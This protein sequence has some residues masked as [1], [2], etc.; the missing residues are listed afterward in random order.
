M[1][2]ILVKIWSCLLLAALIGWLIGW[3]LGK[4]F[5]RD[6]AEQSDAELAGK[7]H[8]CLAERRRLEEANRELEADLMSM[9]NAVVVPFDTDRND[10]LAELE[11]TRQLLRK[12]Q[13]QSEGEK[14]LLNYPNDERERLSRELPTI[15]FP[16]DASEITTESQLTLDKV[17]PMLKSLNNVVVEIE[18][19]TDSIDN[20]EHNS[21]LSQQRANAVRDYLIMRGISSSM[22]RAVGYGAARPL[23]DNGTEEGR[24]RNRRIEFYVKKGTQS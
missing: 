9:Q 11:T 14:A 23:S 5:H 10:L 19:H 15:Q 18:G 2:I 20:E 7:L 12:V 6:S 24:Q 22:L 21:H 8:V 17:L 1:E 4:R 13:A 3:L 16:V